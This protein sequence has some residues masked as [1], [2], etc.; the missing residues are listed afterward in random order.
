MYEV[1]GASGL[2]GYEVIKIQVHAA[3]ELFGR[4]YPHREGYASS[5]SW[6]TDGWSYLAI[7]RPGAEK[8]FAEVARRPKNP[9]ARLDTTPERSEGVS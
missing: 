4:W 9:G 7:D 5:E 2:L 1:R 6:G 8:R 3:G